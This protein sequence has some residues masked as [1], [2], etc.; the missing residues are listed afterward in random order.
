MDFDWETSMLKG[1]SMAMH[2]GLHWGIPMDWSKETSTY[3]DW[4]TETP[5]DW[6]KETS[7]ETS[8]YWDW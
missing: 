3:W 1:T 8:T 2:S 4:S 5:M 6:P 7:T